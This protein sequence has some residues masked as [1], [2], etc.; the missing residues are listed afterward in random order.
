M[1][2]LVVEGI[3]PCP[4]KALKHC[5]KCKQ[6]SISALP[7]AQGKWKFV[8]NYGQWF[9]KCYDQSC[10]HIYWHNERTPPVRIPENVQLNAALCQSAV[11]AEVPLYCQEPGCKTTQGICQKAN[12][13]CS[14][15]PQHCS[16]CCKAKG[17]HV[18]E[19]HWY[20]QQLLPLCGPL[21][22][23]SLKITGGISTDC[24][25]EN[26]KVVTKRSGFLVL[27]DHPAIT[28][29]LEGSCWVTYYDVDAVAMPEWISQDIGTPIIMPP[30]RKSL[31]VHVTHLNRRFLQDLNEKVAYALY[32]PTSSPVPSQVTP[33]KQQRQDSVVSQDAGGVAEAIITTNLVF[34]GP[35]LLHVSDLAPCLAQMIAH[36]K[37]KEGFAEA[38]PGYKFT[39]STI[40]RY[41]LNYTKAVKAGVLQD[42][43]NLGRS[44]GG[45]W[46]ELV[47]FLSTLPTALTPVGS[48]VKSNA[49]AV[50]HSPI[51][52]HSLDYEI[53]DFYFTEFHCHNGEW[54]AFHPGTV[55][56]VV[57]QY[58][59]LFATGTFMNVYLMLE[60][61]GSGQK[62]F[63]IKRSCL[64]GNW[65]EP[66]KNKDK[67]VWLDCRRLAEF[68]R[69]VRQFTSEIKAKQAEIFTYSFTVVPL[70]LA[71]TMLW[72]AVAQ[73]CVDGNEFLSKKELLDLG[74]IGFMQPAN[75]MYS[76]SLTNCQTHSFD[77]EEGTGYYCGNKG[78][79]GVQHFVRY[80]HASGCNPTCK[81]LGLP[82]IL[83]SY[84]NP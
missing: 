42:F 65:W 10:G 26:I 6:P 68:A 46:S 37:I 5:P 2:T 55:H 23:P 4:D 41:C 66:C 49:Q 84:C 58:K 3:N 25:Y 15:T 72:S 34:P 82:N 60:D 74:N 64:A 70:F 9:Q 61:P 29:T 13:L 27:A 81:T 32:I 43:I 31:L 22:E 47:K 73:D 56:S 48:A 19:D 51:L 53:L 7:L 57:L 44:D 33:H 14:R 77:N 35:N 52:A 36:K 80:H 39:D 11:K 83:D 28:D 59:L 50:S 54:Q 45:K 79:D 63:V 67:A 78:F 69:F 30:N 17:G 18:A 8:T 16:P 20:S 76:L 12:K 71:E 62:S 1:S 40:Y 24:L 38:F 75:A 21:A